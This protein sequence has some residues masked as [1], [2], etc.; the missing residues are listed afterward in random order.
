[1][2]E[3]Q[4]D[5]SAAVQRVADTIALASKK[6]TGPQ[7]MLL[8][9]GM[10][11]E[12]QMLE[13]DHAR[14]VG[15]LASE[16]AAVGAAIGAAGFLSGPSLTACIHALATEYRHFKA[17]AEAAEADAGR[18][19]WLARYGAGIRQD[20]VDKGWYLEAPYNAAWRTFER[21]PSP[22]AA[23]DAALAA[24]AGGGGA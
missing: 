18:L 19:D 17:K 7:F 22:R 6:L 10:G 3:V 13:A 4:R 2:S 12:L 24:G 9:G 5:Y 8:A 11:A 15:E 21:F 14:R 16:V 20:P 1:M 23:I